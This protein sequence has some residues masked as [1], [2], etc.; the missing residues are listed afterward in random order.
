[1]WIDPYPNLRGMLTAEYIARY[2]NECQMIEDFRPENLKTSSYR[3]TLGRWCQ[4]DGKDITLSNSEPFLSVP[5]N[6]LAFVSVGERLRLPHYIA[7]RF[8][9][10]IDLVYKGLL[11][12]TG[13]QVDPGF[14]GVL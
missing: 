12:G 6:S 14:Q 9:L 8:N 11:L 4:V 10:M 2:A 7:A 5:P 1:H 3:L 13:P